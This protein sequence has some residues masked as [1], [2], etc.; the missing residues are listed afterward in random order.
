[1]AR[2][3]RDMARFDRRNHYANECPNRWEVRGWRTGDFSQVPCLWCKN[4]PYVKWSWYGTEGKNKWNKACRRE[5]R[6][7]AKTAMRQC[8]DW[9]N[10]SIKYRRPYWD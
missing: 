8:R 10:L 2:T 1:M 4:E 7:R 5:E 9:D 3:D 6:G